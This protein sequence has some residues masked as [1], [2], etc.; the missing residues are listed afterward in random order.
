MH[1]RRSVCMMMQQERVTTTDAASTA[2]GYIDISTYVVY[3][4]T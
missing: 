4:R 1:D 3:V 2:S